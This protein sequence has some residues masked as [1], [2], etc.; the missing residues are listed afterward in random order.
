ML[1]FAI[2]S[3]R[4]EIREKLLHPG[5]TCVGKN[6]IFFDGFMNQKLCSFDTFLCFFL[7][8]YKQLLK[9]ANEKTVVMFG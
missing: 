1:P 4:R 5:N 6:T 8:T 9:S 3:E 7:G 2:N